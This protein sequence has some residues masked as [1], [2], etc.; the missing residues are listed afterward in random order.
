MK[1]SIKLGLTALALSVTLASCFDSDDKTKKTDTPAVKTDTLA[2]KRPDTLG[3]DTMGK[4]S[5]PSAETKKM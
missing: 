1:N 5:N 2:I 3:A 4:N